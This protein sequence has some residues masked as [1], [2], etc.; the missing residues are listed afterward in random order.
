MRSLLDSSQ[1]P[2]RALQHQAVA[3]LRA[4]GDREWLAQMLSYLGGEIAADGDYAAARTMQAESVAIY[5]E[6]GD[7][8]GLATPLGYLGYLSLRQHDYVAARNY[9]GESLELMLQNGNPW[10]VAWRLEGF[11]GLAA[12]QGQVERAARLFGATEAALSAV[13]G[14]FDAVDRMDYERHVA[15]A[16]DQL[17]E[18]AFAAAWAE[19]RAMTLEQAVAYALEVE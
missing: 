11:A 3:L 15:A 13:H 18:E 1:G 8:F 12:L 14:T 19:G 9:F 4:A 2:G 7:P 10:M 17:G 6:Q 16:R 5:R